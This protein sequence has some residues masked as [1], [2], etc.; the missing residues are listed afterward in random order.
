M[1]IALVLPP[2][3]KIAEGKDTPRY[4]HVG[5]GYLAAMLEREG[6]SVKVINAKL[7]RMN[8]GETLEAI[9]CIDPDVV[10]ITAMTHEINVAGRLADE[11]K[12]WHSD[13]VI[14][15]GG[16]HV[17]ALPEE[18]LS[19][20]RS[21]DF[22]IIGEG[23]HVFCA[24][25]RLLEKKDFDFSK[26]TGVVYHEGSLVKLSK[27]AQRIIDLD[28]LPFPSWRQFPKATEYIIITSRGCPFS[29][30]FC[31]QALGRQ[32]RKRSPENVVQEIE[33]VIVTRRP[34]RFLFYDETFTLEKGRVDKICDLIIKK[35]LNKKIRWAVTTRV[36]SVDRDLLLKL[37]EAGCNHIE[38]GIESGD[39]KILE[40]IQKK[41]TLTQAQEAVVLAKKM[42]FHTEGAF[43]LGH[44]HETLATAYRTIHFAARLNPDI[45]QLGIMVPYPGT[46]VGRLAREGKGGYKVISDNWS[47]YNKQLGNALEL[48]HLSRKD[49]ER[50]QFIGYLKLFIFNKRFFD[51]IAFAWNYKREF[52]SFIKNH[53]RRDKTYQKTQIGMSAVMKMIL[54]PSPEL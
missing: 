37:K 16:V 22:G 19:A 4:Q 1:K 15:V 47:D 27:P 12:L 44:P 46:E 48:E 28:S 13:I 35:G 24:A 40:S 49:L 23:E 38:F 42:G 18:T 10:G 30:I 53:L 34:S 8:F 2:A 5:L 14:A 29:C 9:R 52:F 3:E 36:D 25:L 17:T 7:E 41:I 50:L 32:V 54:N 43:I 39:Q 11:V 33:S 20:Y 21:F 51:F 6:F 45:I 31:M 26:L